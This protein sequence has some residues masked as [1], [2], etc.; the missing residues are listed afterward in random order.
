MSKYRY[1]ANPKKDRRI[2]SKGADMIH[3]KNSMSSVTRGGYRL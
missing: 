3:K 2:F 1:R